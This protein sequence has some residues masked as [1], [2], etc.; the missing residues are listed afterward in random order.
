MVELSD[1]TQ[2]TVNRFLEVSSSPGSSVFVHLCLC[3]CVS[4]NEYLH[5]F[6]S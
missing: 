5:V 6:T 3:V 2:G 4:G 1:C